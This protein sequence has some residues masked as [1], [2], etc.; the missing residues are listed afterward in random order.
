[1]APKNLGRN[2]AHRQNPRL[3]PEKKVSRPGTAE[4]LGLPNMSRHVC[5][6]LVCVVAVGCYLNSLPGDFVHDD[7]MAIKT[8]KD[9][10]GK[11]PL[12]EV[13]MNDFWGK[14]MSDN[15][16]HKSYRPLC[17]L[18]FRI[19][20]L[21]GGLDP[22]GFHAV[23]V[24]LH[25]A[26]TVLYMY[27]CEQVVFSCVHLSLL[28]GLMFAVH[29]VHTEAV[30]GIVGRA[31]VLAGLLFL[32]SFLAFTRSVS[33]VWSGASSH[34]QYVLCLLLGACAMLVKEQGITVLGVCVLYD[35][36]ICRR[37]ILRHL[38][39]R[40]FSGFLQDSRPLLK[41]SAVTGMVLLCLLCFRVWMLNGTLPQFSDQDNPASFS[42]YLATR[43]LTYSYLLVF[44]AWLLLAPITLCYDWQMGSIPLVESLLDTRNL[45]TFAFVVTMVSLTAYCLFLAED[46]A[47]MVAVLGLV[48]LVL[49]FLP[50]SNVFIRVGFVVAERI[51]YIPSMGYFIL[52]VHGLHN[53]CCALGKPVSSL[54]TGCALLLIILWGWKT[55]NRNP[56]WWTRESL[57]R[58]GVETLPHNAKAHYNYGNY[59]KDLGRH[60]EAI[61]HYQRTLELYPRHASA[62]NNL[63]TLMT[64]DTQLQERY[65]RRAMNITPQHAKAHFNLANLIS[66]QGKTSEAETLFRRAI[67]IQPDYIDAHVNLASL[68]SDLDRNEE[69]MGI[70]HE[71]LDL[72]GENPDVLNN[73]GAFLAK[74]GQTAE[75]LS[76]Y[77]QALTFDPTHTVAMVNKARLLRSLDRTQEAESLFLRAISLK[78]EAGTLELLAAMYYNTGRIMD[79]KTVYE[80]ILSIDP[81]RHETVTHYAHV[82]GRLGDHRKAEELLR[83]VLD[84]RP[85]LFD[86]H[87]HL[88]SLYGMMGSSQKA[89][90]SALQALELLPPNYEAKQTAE[91]HYE[92]G[93][94]HKDLNHISQ[95]LDSYRMA[96]SL[97]P[98]LASAHMNLGALLHI[99]EE[100]Q[101]ARHHYQAALKLDPTNQILM[102]NIR[103]LDRKEQQMRQDS[104][105]PAGNR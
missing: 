51:L 69:A 54:M 8:N 102:D 68:L 58:S 24:L 74:L 70:Y 67:V 78:K 37:G 64:N 38:R 65:Y 31:D 7:V 30:S 90:Q 63:G 10:L 25:T 76:H 43:F 14:R 104:S 22:T 52:L 82:V 71:S 48:L 18:T 66:K 47:G 80:E 32:L 73:Y 13:F 59:L 99:K 21:I 72:D 96:V 85:D 91:L 56:T 28:T 100:I 97:Y 92:L 42:P 61:F 60:E 55:I 36:V 101:E 4:D 19:N 16:S 20:H 98:N 29:P 41:R 79:A 15:T 49:P 45:A 40:S 89:L 33:P 3:S 35:T 62:N 83:G 17:V 2:G 105:K 6:I 93:N 39:E 1:M 50:A 57:F 94:H 84:R 88:A 9:V 46:E 53:L 75:A 44:N 103:K 12:S 81:D 26:V 95:A 11:T 27:V 87:R 77:D 23:N 86:A 34:G 5:Y